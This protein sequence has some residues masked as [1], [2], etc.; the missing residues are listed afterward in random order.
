MQELSWEIAKAETWIYL[1]LIDS[2]HLRHFWE[3]YLFLGFYPET[4]NFLLKSK[5]QTVHNWPVK[6]YCFKQQNMLTFA[7]VRVFGQ[8]VFPP[9]LPLRNSGIDLGM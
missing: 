7:E 8:P 5:E 6:K 9:I 3:E 2:F 1:N 4:V